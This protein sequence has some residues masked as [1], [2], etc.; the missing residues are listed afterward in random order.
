[1]DK[2]LIIF[3]TGGHS[4]VVG[5]ITSIPFQPCYYETEFTDH[6]KISI[7]SM[8]DVY[9]VSEYDAF[10]AIGDNRARQYVFEELTSHKYNMINVI[11]PS[12][13]VYGELEG[14]GI[15]IG[16]NTIIQVGA[17][18]HDGVIVNTAATIDHD[19]T[20]GAFTHI[21]PGVNIC[22]HVSIGKR[23]LIGAG[24]A[25]IP[26]VVLGDDV[27]IGAGAAVVD[28]HSSG[29]KLLGV[30]ARARITESG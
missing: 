24:S 6:N 27:I 21:A 19:S 13:I 2:K 4:K 20:V 22:G 26:K 25:I 7:Y 11:H 23:C 18:I 16:P 3:G 14:A 28:S 29:A 17:V 1:M 5:K 8:L 12:A 10:V 9:P 15:Y 30:P